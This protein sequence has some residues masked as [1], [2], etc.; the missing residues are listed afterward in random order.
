MPFLEYNVEIRRVICTTNATTAINAGYR[1]A[2]R[3]SRH[4]PNQTATLKF[5]Y[6]VGWSL[7]L[8]GGEQVGLVMRWIPALNAFTTVTFT[9]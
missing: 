7:D 2:A 6:L 5:P 1:H 4:F 9:G 3:A 8:T